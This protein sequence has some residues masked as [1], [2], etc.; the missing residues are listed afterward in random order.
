MNDVLDV[1]FRIGIDVGNRGIQN[2]ETSTFIY[3]D[4]INHLMDVYYLIF[5]QISPKVCQD[6]E[7]Q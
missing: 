7:Y 2:A 6:I 1:G 4:P 5:H 3:F